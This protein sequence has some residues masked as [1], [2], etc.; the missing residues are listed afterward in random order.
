MEQL[1]QSK[2]TPVK[3]QLNIQ[4][5]R[6]EYE[7]YQLPLADVTTIDGKFHHK[8]T[9]TTMKMDTYELRRSLGFTKTGD[10]IREAADRGKQNISEFMTKAADTG[11]QLSNAHKGVTIASI[12]RQRMLEHP[13]SVTIFI[14]NGQV[15][16]SWQTG[17][18]ET[19]YETG[20]IDYDWKITEPNR[21]YIPGFV[22]LKITQKPHVTTTYLG[23]PQYV[24]P[25]ADPNYK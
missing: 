4:N 23:S 16:M 11:R 25:S 2:S 22:K 14:P 19:T 24:P 15:D 7:H 20:S 8:T 3:Y 9:P 17:G 10:M 6:Q 13:Q 21:N 5:A 1:L 18:V 12:T